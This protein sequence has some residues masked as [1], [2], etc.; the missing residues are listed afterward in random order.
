MP[1]LC[2]VFRKPSVQSFFM[3]DEC[4]QLKK[5]NFAVTRTMM[6]KNMIQF[7]IL[8]IQLRNRN[9]LVYAK[10]SVLKDPSISIFTATLQQTT[11][12]ISVFTYTTT[13]DTRI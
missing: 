3:S 6:K 10:I 2:L 7:C 13:A 12:H 1:E 11:Y 8:S 5:T 9:S 4:T